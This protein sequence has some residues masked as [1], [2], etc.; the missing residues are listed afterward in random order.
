[1]NVPPRG[2]RE[3]IP[4]WR[5]YEETMLIG[6]LD[7]PRLSRP[8]SWSTNREG[9][10]QRERDWLERG[11]LAYA[12]ELIGSATVL[13]ANTP[14]AIEA[15]KKVLT[16]KTGLPS[17]EAAAASLLERNAAEGERRQIL[18]ATPAVRPEIK[19][20]RA[21][22]RRNPRNAIRWC[23]LAR[24]HTIGGHHEKARRAI[25][26]ARTLA[27]HDRYVLRSAARFEIHLHNPDKAASMLATVAARTEDPWLVAAALGAAG[28]AG[29]SS[30][31]VRMGNRLLT[32]GGHAPLELGELASALGTIEAHAGNDREARRLF[33]QALKDPTDNAVAQAEWASRNVAGVPVPAAAGEQPESWEARAWVAAGRNDH[34]RAVQEA[35]KWFYDQPF[36]SR[37]A[38]FGSYHASIDGRYEVGAEIA[39]AGLSANPDDFLLL[40]NLAFCLA[41]S[42][43]AVEAEEVYSRVRPASLSDEQLPT[44]LATRGLIAFRLGRVEEGRHLYRESAARWGDEVNR[45]IGMIMLAR[46]ELRIR[47]PYAA[48]ADERARRASKAAG[49]GDL[50][51]WLRQVDPALVAVDARPAISAKVLPA[52][53]APTLGSRR[54]LP[55]A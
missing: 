14:A 52:S 30:S 9:H 31:L 45:A 33:R 2:R 24:H 22:L 53:P 10:E 39:L 35:W 7:S 6:E 41:S 18:P 48:E 16:M 50:D 26:V 28:I 20:Y 12:A 13:D 54:E 21:S 47:S 15:A 23:E 42:G 3:V 27:P 55:P 43:Q 51:R 36:A 37:P 29:V 25:Q 34:A 49:H 4:R 5:S 38:E 17:L 32:S 46:E 40:N 44:Y 11:G 1:M 19:R 8:R